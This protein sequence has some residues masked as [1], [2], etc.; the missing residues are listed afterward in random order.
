VPI[1]PVLE[2]L[3][4]LDPVGHLEEGKNEDMFGGVA[5]GKTAGEC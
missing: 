4:D 3:L 1:P 2:E 5:Y